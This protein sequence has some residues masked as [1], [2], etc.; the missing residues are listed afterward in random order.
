MKQEMQRGEDCIDTGDGRGRSSTIRYMNKYLYF[1]TFSANSSA[2][3][4]RSF[5]YF[6]F[7]LRLLLRTHRVSIFRAADG[8]RVDAEADL[9]R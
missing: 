3:P 6:P 8:Y 9:I 1:C 2:S 7:S 5:P 4:R